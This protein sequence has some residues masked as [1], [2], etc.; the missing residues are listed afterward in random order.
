MLEVLI[1]TVFSAQ[2]YCFIVQL[3]YTFLALKAQLNQTHESGVS[4]IH[5][6]IYIVLVEVVRFSKL[7]AVEISDG[8]TALHLW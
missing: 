3:L 2:Y 6:Y 5:L 7:S 4:F 1:M 8:D